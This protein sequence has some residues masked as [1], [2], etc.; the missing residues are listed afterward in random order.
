[1]W[2]FCHAIYLLFVFLEKYLQQQGSV[3]TL[4][5]RCFYVIPTYNEAVFAQN[6]KVIWT[7]CKDCIICTMSFQPSQGIRFVVV[8]YWKEKSAIAWKL[9]APKKLG[10][11]IMSIKFT[12]DI[13]RRA[14]SPDFSFDSSGTRHPQKVTS[15]NFLHF[16]NPPCPPHARMASSAAKYC[17][18]ND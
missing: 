6:H 2:A 1:M 16:S 12:D 13:R 10:S 4:N 5:M 17:I 15:V 11:Q 14:F 9:T 7:F 3:A 8:F 18:R